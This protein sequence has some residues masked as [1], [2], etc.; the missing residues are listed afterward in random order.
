MKRHI[1]LHGM[2]GERFGR[3]H[4]FDI[5]T[6]AEAIRALNANFDDFLNVFAA[7]QQHYR[8]IA[9]DDVIP[10]V[11]GLHIPLSR[12]VQIVPVIAGAKGGIGGILLGGAL[13]AASFYLPGSALFT[14]GTFSPSFASIAFGLGASL[15]LGGVS[16]LLSP[17]PKAGKP[18]ESP[19]NEP[20]Y[21]F[22]G[23]VNTTAQGQ[24]VPVGYGRL[25]VGGAVISAGLTADDYAAAGMA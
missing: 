8:V 23:P 1:I 22:N 25:I 18:A 10:A 13:I 14:V 4:Y 11:D 21:S 19:Q 20:S 3:D 7:S 12:T 17:M 15:A 16:Q 24:P 9:D 5:A 6:P 2:L